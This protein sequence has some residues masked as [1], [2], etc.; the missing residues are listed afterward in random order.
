MQKEDKLLKAQEHHKTHIVKTHSKLAKK[1][2]GIDMQVFCLRKYIYYRKN[3]YVCLLVYEV[4]IAFSLLF[5]RFIQ[6]LF[7]ST[8]YAIIITA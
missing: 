4:N 6:I 3:I 2:S 8:F 7:H 1:S 5:I